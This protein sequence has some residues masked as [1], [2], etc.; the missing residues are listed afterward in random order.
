MVLVL[1]RVH[2]LISAG[3]GWIRD[4][5]TGV[6][7]LVRR[8]WTLIV[9]TVV[10]RVLVVVLCRVGLAIV[11]SVLVNVALAVAAGSAEALEEHV[12]GRGRAWDGGRKRVLKCISRTEEL[13]NAYAK[14]M[15]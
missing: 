6:G 8:A 3:V 7:L 5:C 15:M 9:A 2:G 13:T 10:G 1:C 14:W 12:E 11:W 4:E